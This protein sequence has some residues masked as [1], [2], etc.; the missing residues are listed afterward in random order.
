VLIDGLPLTPELIPS[1]QATIGYVPQEIFLIDDTIA[2]NIALG[3]PDNEIDDARL[4]EVCVTAQ[5]L[6][7]IEAELRDGFQTTAGERGVRL[8]GGQRQ[9]LGLARAL[10]HRPSLLLLDEATSAL[11]TA[12]EAKL[13]EALHSLTGKLTIVMATHRLSSVGSYHEL[14]N[15][16]TKTAAISM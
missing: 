12:T 13:L 3:V 6:D 14:I 15:L 4:Q 11:D 1:W 7:F 5:I 9:R 10:Y 2:R 16:G 8:S